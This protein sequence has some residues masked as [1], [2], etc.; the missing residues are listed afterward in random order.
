MMQPCACALLLMLAT[1]STKIS[2]L[3]LEVLAGCLKE[4]RLYAWAF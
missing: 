3:I 2:V 1:T 4:F